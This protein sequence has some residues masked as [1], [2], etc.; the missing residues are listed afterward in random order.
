MA[1]RVPF[2]GPGMTDPQGWGPVVFLPWVHHGVRQLR[3]L[4]ACPVLIHRVLGSVYV[5]VWDVQGWLRKR[6]WRTDRTRHGAKH[7]AGKS[8][9]QMSLYLGLLTCV[10]EGLG[11]EAD[12]PGVRLISFC[13]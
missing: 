2:C 9:R 3:T 8:L 11:T 13:V 12:M 7:R 1:V 4:L 10:L 6:R 5:S